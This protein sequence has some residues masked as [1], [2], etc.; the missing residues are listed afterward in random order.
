MGTVLHPAALRCIRRGA[1]CDDP[2]DRSRAVHGMGG[3]VLEQSGFPCE[4]SASV[5]RTGR[6]AAD[7]LGAPAIPRRRG[8]HDG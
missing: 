1:R 3:R 6:E 5:N 7:R 8:R 4:D 2:S